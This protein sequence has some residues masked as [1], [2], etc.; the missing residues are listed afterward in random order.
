MR[1]RAKRFRSSHTARQHV[2][3]AQ[4]T[5]SHPSVLPRLWVGPRAQAV[6]GAHGSMLRRPSLVGG[7]RG[8]EQSLILAAAG[9]AVHA[10][11]APIAVSCRPCAS[12]SKPSIGPTRARPLPS[13]LVPTHH[14]QGDLISHSAAWLWCRALNI[15]SC[16]R[17]DLDA[18]SSGVLVN[19]ELALGT[20]VRAYKRTGSALTQWREDVTQALAQGTPESSRSPQPA[21]LERPRW[22]PS[23]GGCHRYALRSAAT[24]SGVVTG[25]SGLRSGNLLKMNPSGQSEP[26]WT[27]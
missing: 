25:R 17:S 7:A 9:S 1:A 5:W 23:Y 14:R 16:R 18:R 22:R 3:F 2:P 27:I 15:A 8:T 24:D 10:R 12:F 26:Y 20:N 6:Q 21:A 11:E 4:R 13:I 19:K